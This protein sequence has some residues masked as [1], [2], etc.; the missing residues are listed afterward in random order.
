MARFLIGWELCASPDLLI[1]IADVALALLHRGH[2]V[3]M[4]V[5]D[6]VGLASVVDPSLRSAILPAPLPP[7]R[8]DL[9]M[10]PPKEGGFADKLFAQGFNSPAILG[11]LAS[12]WR[13][14]ID[15]VAPD[16]IL[17]IGAPVLAFAARGYKPLLVAGS[18]ESLPPPELETWPRLHANI[19]PSQTDDRLVAITGH[20]AGVL[21]AAPVRQPTD[22]LRADRVIVYGMPQI[23]PYVALRAAPA[24][25]PLRPLPSPVV[26]AG[27]PAMLAAL[28]VYHPDIETLVLA[29]TDFGNTP[30]HV[31][32]RGMTPPMRSYLTQSPGVVVHERIDEAL[33]HAG[34]ASFVLHHATARTATMCIG[35]GVP[36]ALLPFTVEQNAVADMLQRFNAGMRLGLG[37]DPMPAADS[38][39]MLF[40]N[41]DQVQNA[42]HLARQVDLRAPGPAMEGIVA[43]AEGLAR[44]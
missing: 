9:I 15:A 10:K 13:T 32:I 16:A 28:D 35:M 26:P 27:K 22:I 14:L 23:D 39:A 12:A 36:Q 17:S 42:Q 19:A 5:S 11:G 7:M 34:E 1:D 31:H 18:G 44:P 3:R 33:R 30:V 21:G 20:V 38:L 40:R 37:T 24:A 2:M 41:I 43:A 8:P 25:G 29:L 6:P 4:A